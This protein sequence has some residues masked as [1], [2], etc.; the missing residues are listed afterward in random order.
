[1]DAAKDL[2]YDYSYK[3]PGGGAQAAAAHRSP[4]EG[5]LGPGER[6]LWAGRPPQRLLMLYMGDL[7][8]IPFFLFWTGFACLWEAVAIGGVL[9]GGMDGP[10][11]CMPLFGLPFVAIGVFMLGGRF[12]GD[13]LGRRSTHYALTDRRVM[14]V[15]GRRNQNLISVPLDKI[16]NVGMTI[17]RNGTGTLSFASPGVVQPGG[18]TYYKGSMGSGQGTLP[19]FDHIPGPKTVYDLVLKAQ[20]DLMVRQHGY[21]PEQ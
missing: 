5:L 12:V 10:G 6:V 2:E 17:H 4:I 14:I 16:D 21:T 8:I 7:V 20:D 11:L 19:A 3:P 1:V 15:T 9:A 18:Y 13:T